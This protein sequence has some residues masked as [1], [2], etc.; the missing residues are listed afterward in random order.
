MIVV[1]V[2]VIVKVIRINI[3][4]IVITL[5]ISFLYKF[6]LNRNSLSIIV[7]NIPSKYILENRR[8][9]ILYSQ[10]LIS[11]IFY[12][13]YH[14]VQKDEEKIWHIVQFEQGITH[15]KKSH[16]YIPFNRSFRGQTSYLSIRICG[17]KLYTRQH[18][19][20]APNFPGDS[21]T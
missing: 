10:K 2:N 12:T 5:Y 20:H 9:N 4:I 8:K 1:L 16:V 11:T 15:I 7:Y 3:F 17:I 18:F 19:E 14:H 21:A 6:S 13:I